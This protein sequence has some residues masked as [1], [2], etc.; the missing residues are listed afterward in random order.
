MLRT[1]ASRRPVQKRSM[2][3]STIIAPTA[4]QASAERHCGQR[5]NRMIRQRAAIPG[6]R[7]PATDIRNRQINAA[8]AQG[9][10]PEQHGIAWR[11]QICGH[12]IPEESLQDQQHVPEGNDM[13]PAQQRQYLVAPGAGDADHGT[14][15]G[16]RRPPH[17]AQKQGVDDA[18]QKKR[19]QEAIVVTGINEKDTSQPVDL[20]RSQSPAP[21]LRLHDGLC[22]APAADEYGHHHREEQRL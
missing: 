19:Q 1:E 7:P 16:G 18:G 4:R 21:F 22:I 12:H 6:Q 17:R 2:Q 14:D 11:R 3:G 10:R 5:P 20:C 13:E 8:I 15:Q 9:Q